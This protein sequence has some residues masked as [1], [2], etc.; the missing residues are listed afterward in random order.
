MFSKEHSLL[1][2]G[3]KFPFIETK[4]RETP[5]LGC[6]EILRKQVMLKR[7]KQSTNRCLRISS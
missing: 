3:N 7:L 6:A 1:K 4:G 2:N 5:N